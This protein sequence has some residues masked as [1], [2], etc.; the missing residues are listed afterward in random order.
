MGDPGRFR[1]VA[2]AIGIAEGLE[3]AAS[4][5]AAVVRETAGERNTPW[6]PFNLFDFFALAFEAVPLIPD[7]GLF[8]DVGAGPGS[9]MILAREVLGLDV[10][11]FERSDV[12][13]ALGRTIGLDIATAN[14]E[15]WTGYGKYGCVWLNR[16]L[17]AAAAELFL[18][19]RVYGEMTPGAVLICANTE[20]RP[21][22]PWIVVNDS[23]QDL[24]RGA[25]IKPHGS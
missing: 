21:P 8:L 3:R 23:W 2:T 11:G 12:L 6:M 18:E 1:D 25:W 24:R 17:R 20:T 4:Q 13:A 5:H 15:D 10:H 16:P 7:P 9:K 19:E 14:A 22:Q